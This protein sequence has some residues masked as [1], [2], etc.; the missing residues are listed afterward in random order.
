VD[1]ES[2]TAAGQSIILV[3]VMRNLRYFTPIPGSLVDDAFLNERT[4]PNR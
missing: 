4:A 1:A 2:Q 3:L